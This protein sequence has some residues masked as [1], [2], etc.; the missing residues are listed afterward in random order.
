MN[1]IDLLIGLTLMNTMPHYILGI[2]KVRMISGFGTGS[3]R[4][5]LWALFNFFLS[6]GLFVYAYGFGAF[7]ANGIYAGA[8]L[9]Q[10]IFFIAAPFWYWYFHHRQGGQQKKSRE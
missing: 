5:I 7:A 10:L 6:V 2:W 4:N 8:V 1:I 9:L 3:A